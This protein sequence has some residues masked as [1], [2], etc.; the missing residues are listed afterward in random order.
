MPKKL[1][2]IIASDEGTPRS[3][4]FRKRSLIRI[5]LL[6]A[7]TIAALVV[8]SYLGMDASV[9]NL[10]L[11]GTV[12]N[13]EHSLEQ[14]KTR[15]GSFRRQVADLRREK[16]ALLEGAVG[17]LEKRSQLIDT[18]LENIGIDDIAPAKGKNSQ[19]GSGGPFTSLDNGNHEDL[20]FKVDS[21]L[22]L[23][24]QIPLGPP[25]PGD[26]TS[27]Y[28][29][30]KDPI[31]GRPAF[32]NGVDLRGARG[33]KIFAT[34][35]GRVAKVGWENGYGQLVLLDHGNGFESIY[36]HCRKILVKNWDSISRGD[37][38]ALVGNTGRST[39]PHVHYEIRYKGKLLNPYKF[40]RVQ[41]FLS[42]AAAK[43]PREG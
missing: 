24:R 32:H 19:G 37:A 39:G 16:D 22:E 35:D 20:L 14:E 29:R 30:R 41:R 18:I 11:K 7:S 42:N 17:D 9:E 13:L 3:F 23:I 28:G 2:V 15:N 1:H 21:T 38:I 33:E 10:N 36:G 6:S 31:N 27:S 43:V 5:F 25:V 26:I 12:D 40:L 34:A 4:A 8:I